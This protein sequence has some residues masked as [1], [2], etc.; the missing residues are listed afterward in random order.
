MIE[1]IKVF[2]KEI[3]KLFPQYKIFR[4][5]QNPDD[6]NVKIP[7]F[8]F[9]TGRT[10]VNF[11]QPE[12]IEKVQAGTVFSSGLLTLNSDLNFIGNSAE[13]MDIAIK[14]IHDFFGVD[15][16]CN[17]FS[18][19]SRDFDFKPLPEAQDFISKFNIRLL[20][21]MVDTDPS[22][23]QSGFGHRCVFQL[24]SYVPSFKLQKTST[25]KKT[26]LDVTVS[27]T[28]NINK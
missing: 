21:I 17:D 19:C 24:S 16:L 18:T 13:S 11:F 27:E 23:S 4:N 20:N 14:T 28:V 15:V 6:Q 26:E 2:L 10:D 1:A 12:D 22:L 8:V 25:L 3:E 9:F 5:W 7:H